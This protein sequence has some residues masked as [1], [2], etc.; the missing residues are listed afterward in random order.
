MPGPMS[1]FDISGRAMS[2]QL[3]RLNTTA[4][5][6]ANA[7]TTY[8]SEKEAYRAIKPVFKTI[9]E[10]PGVATVQVEKVVQSDIKPVKRH[11]P[12]N[13]LADDEG[14]V[15]DAGVDETAELIDMLETAR[16]YQNNVQVMQTA[17]S[18]ILDTV[19]MGK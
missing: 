13:P 8:A 17:K 5:N 19:R 7:R 4:S 11:D 16:Q 9:E 3:S 14:Y 10:R 6:L 1:V 2:A 12:T 15:W 18:L